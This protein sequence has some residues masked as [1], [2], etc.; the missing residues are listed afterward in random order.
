MSI[1]HAEKIFP[2]NM[3]PLVKSTL[4]LAFSGTCPYGPLED[5]A[6]GETT[7]DA[8]KKTWDVLGREGGFHVL[9]LPQKKSPA[10]RALWLEEV[11]DFARPARGPD[12]PTSKPEPWPGPSG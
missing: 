12:R 3:C 5:L 1:P 8:K 2:R 10:D 9:E 7:C 11:R 6:V 4:G